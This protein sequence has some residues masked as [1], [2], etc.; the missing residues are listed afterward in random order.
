MLQIDFFPKEII[1]DYENEVFNEIL[2]RNSN[3]QTISFIPNTSYTISIHDLLTLSRE[4]LLQLNGIK[5]YI[6]ICSA[7]KYKTKSNVELLHI[8]SDEYPHLVTQHKYERGNYRYEINSTTYSTTRKDDN[9]NHAIINEATI[10]L[11]N[12]F[13]SY[14]TSFTNIYFNNAPITSIKDLN[15]ILDRI[16]YD[17][18]HQNINRSKVPIIDYDILSGNM[19]H[20]LMNSIGIRTCP[21]CNRNYITRYGV[22][23]EKSTADLDHFYQKEQYP[24]FAIQE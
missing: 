4:Q 6:F 2:K 1:Q 19:R 12:L 24:L 11:K 15:S 9:S 8:L 17:I 18:E 13:L 21:Y 23:G 3:S 10:L 16:F 5:F 22:D 14:N 7:Q 20:R